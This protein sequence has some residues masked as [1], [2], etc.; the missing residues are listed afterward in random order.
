EQQS[1]VATANPRVAPGG[2]EERLRLGLGEEGDDL[3][4]E[5]LARNGLDALDQECVLG[6]TEGREPEEGVNSRQ[7]AVP[8][9]D[10][11]AS[12]FLEIR[13]EV[14]YQRRR[15]R[16]PPSAVPLGLCP[17]ARERSGTGAGRCPDYAFTVWELARR[18]CVRRILKNASRVAANGVI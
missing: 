7:P 1:V 16:D 18:C 6:G 9:S 15:R 5:P 4:V 13:E 14:A 17:C 2:S 8:G 11:V 12:H 10:G 3:P